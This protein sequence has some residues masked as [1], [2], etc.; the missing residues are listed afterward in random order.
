ME[1]IIVE[2]PDLDSD[3]FSPSNHQKAMSGVNLNDFECSVEAKEAFP[4]KAIV[5]QI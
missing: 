5:D 3:I 2:V 1:S 4:R